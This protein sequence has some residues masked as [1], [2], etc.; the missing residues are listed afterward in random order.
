MNKVE[1]LKQIQECLSG[2]RGWISLKKSDKTM[3][4]EE[5]E[6][7]AKQ[8]GLQVEKHGRYGYTAFK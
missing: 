2:K 7:L 8:A 5:K 6:S 1:L 3:K 4:F